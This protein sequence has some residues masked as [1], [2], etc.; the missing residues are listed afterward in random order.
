MILIKF[1]SNRELKNIN[2]L[3]KR[4]FFPREKC[5]VVAVY[6]KLCKLRCGKAYIDI[7]EHCLKRRYSLL[8]GPSI[9]LPCETTCIHIRN[10]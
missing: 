5:K 10:E 9:V 3:K 6:F 7:V 2:N 4:L 8:L 1:H